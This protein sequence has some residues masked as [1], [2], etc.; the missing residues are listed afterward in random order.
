MTNMENKQKNN[1]DDT[2]FKKIFDKHIVGVPVEVKLVID[3]KNITV[4]CWLCV[5]S[6]DYEHVIV[7]HEYTSFDKNAFMSGKMIYFADNPN[8]TFFVVEKKIDCYNVILNN[9]IKK[10]KKWLK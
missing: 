10:S 5:G 4:W 3:T 6:E 1:I 7:V 9:I 8:C 2:E